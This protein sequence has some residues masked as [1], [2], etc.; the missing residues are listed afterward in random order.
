[1]LHFSMIYCFRNM[2]YGSAAWYTCLPQVW[3]NIRSYHTR[4]V[5]HLQSRHH[6]EDISSVLHRT[7]IIKKLSKCCIFQWY[8]AFAIWYTAM[9]HDILAYRKYDIISVLFIREAYIICKADIISK[10]YHPFCI[11]RISLKNL[12]CLSR[13]KRF[14][15]MVH[16]QGEREKTTDCCFLE[17]TDR[18]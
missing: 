12:S 10:I 7:D 9:P 1:M 14:F 16:P 17:A 6:I 4:S 18:K 5:Y 11:E 13:Q 8:I 2:I 15:Y 3:Y